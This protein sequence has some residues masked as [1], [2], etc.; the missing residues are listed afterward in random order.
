MS[1]KL[2]ECILLAKVHNGKLLSTNYKN[3]NSKLEWECENKHKFFMS[4]QVIKMGCWCCYCAG[5]DKK[6]I[7]NCRELA[8]TKNGECLS[9]T[10]TNT[11]EK[12]QW[13]CLDGHIFWM[14]R[15]A[16]VSGCWCQYCAKNIKYNI[17]DCRKTAEDKGGK[18]LSYNYIGAN[19][20]LEWE[21]AEGHKWITTYSNIKN[22]NSWA[23]R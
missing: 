1:N 8:N 2:E 20:K 7:N 15:S 11:N 10:Y 18:C 5:N 22:Q 21:C 6:T 19:E 13:K 23:F 12:L 9:K 14:S 3:N 4:Y 16:V 17:G